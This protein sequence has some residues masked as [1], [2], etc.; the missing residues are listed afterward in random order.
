MANFGDPLA[1]TDRV[2][3]RLRRRRFLRNY[4]QIGV[5]HNSGFA[6]EGRIA[7]WSRSEAVSF[8]TSGQEEDE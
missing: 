6:G 8:L 7:S 3:R 4:W 2:E 1:G 5:L